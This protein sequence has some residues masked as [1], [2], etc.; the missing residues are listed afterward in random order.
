SF[1]SEA[2]YCDGD[3]IYLYT[4]TGDA[5]ERVAEYGPLEDETRDNFVVIVTDGAA[6]CGNTFTDP[7]PQVEQLRNESPEIQTFVVG[8]GSGIDA[9]QLT[10]MSAAGGRAR[11][12]EPNYYQADNG[13]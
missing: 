11:D 7:T 2:E 5:L 1:L 13:S 12:G 9:E 6:R 8:F 3:Q 4:P 10:N